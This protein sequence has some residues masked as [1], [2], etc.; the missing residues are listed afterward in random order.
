MHNIIVF[1][2]NN[3][4]CTEPQREYRVTKGFDSICYL[5]AATK[6]RKGGN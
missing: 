1:Y 6:R 2:I 5:Y 4:Y 3:T